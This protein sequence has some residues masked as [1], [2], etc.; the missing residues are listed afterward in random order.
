[1]FKQTKQKKKKGTF[2]MLNKTEIDKKSIRH[3]NLHKDRNK[4]G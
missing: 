4:W 1:M 3:R 2:K